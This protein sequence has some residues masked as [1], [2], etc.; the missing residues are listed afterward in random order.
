MAET[1]SNSVRLYTRFIF[2]LKVIQYIGY[3][4]VVFFSLTFLFFT[5]GI[6]SSF[7]PLALV[8]VLLQAT[9]GCLII[10]VITQGLI[11]IVDLLSRIE[12]NTRP[13]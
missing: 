2:I 5:G 4:I 11:A 13:Q 1:P 7:P 10:Y 9:V 6:Q 3:S 12:Q 8:L